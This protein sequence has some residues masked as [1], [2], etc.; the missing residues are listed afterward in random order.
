MASWLPVLVLLSSP[1]PSG[2]REVEVPERQTVP[3]SC[4]EME[5][6][7]EEEELKTVV[8]EDLTHSWPLPRALL[9]Q[10]VFSPCA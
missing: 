9:P 5:N 8:Q 1:F 2:C 3:C 4:M 7:R 10:L 6:R